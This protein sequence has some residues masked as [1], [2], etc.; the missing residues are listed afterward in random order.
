[1]ALA[2]EDE[3]ED[4][5]RRDGMSLTGDHEHMT[6][7][8]TRSWPE[9]NPRRDIPIAADPDMSQP[10]DV[11]TLKSHTRLLDGML[12]GVCL[13]DESGTIRYT[14]P[15]EERL[16]GYQRGEL[17]GRHLS[18]QS[19][20]PPEEDEVMSS[21]VTEQLKTVGSWSGE[22]SNRK[23]DG[24][25]FT[26][27]VR[28]TDVELDGCN[29]RMS[30]REDV[31]E[32]KKV[33][34]KLKNSEHRYRSIFEAAAVSI[35]E[36]DFTQVKAAIDEL[37]A[38]GITDFPRYFAEHPEFVRSAIRMVRILD[39]NDASV[40]MFR[41]KSKDELLVSLERIF[42]PE[43]EQAFAGELVMLAQGEGPFVSETVVKT[44]DGE[45][46]DVLFTVA[47]PHDEPGSSEFGAVQECAHKPNEYHQAQAGRRAVA[48]VARP[49]AGYPGG[50]GG[51]DHG[52]G[53]QRSA[54][55]YK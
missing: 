1:M 15:A 30:V 48:P 16:F 9:A 38:Q 7:R 55:L 5:G 34:E 17:L 51:R 13:S 37:K 28:V 54:N 22:W 49:T 6:I 43:T 4:E 31:T 26:T 3:A 52:H 50:R 23:K 42:L 47:F 33:E 39:V 12:E 53:S 19:A 8:E 46:M 29:Y 14:N 24:T 2:A 41:A 18:V 32:R 40:Q 25:P 20:Y 45:P 27:Y 44:L 21:Q 11:E 35:W 10:A 36:E